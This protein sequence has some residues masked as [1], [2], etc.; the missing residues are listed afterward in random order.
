MFTINGA[1]AAHEE[2]DKGSIEVGKFADFVI[3]DKDPYKNHAEINSINVEATIVGG[4][5]VYGKG[6]FC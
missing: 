5:I 1:W 3:L 4:R 2:R 6:D